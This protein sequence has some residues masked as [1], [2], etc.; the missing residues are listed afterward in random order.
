M[1]QGRQ[2]LSKMD[3]ENVNAGERNGRRKSEGRKGGRGG[4]EVVEGRRER[5]GRKIGRK[6]G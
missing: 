4:K 3:G 6:G 2:R 5:K 1:W